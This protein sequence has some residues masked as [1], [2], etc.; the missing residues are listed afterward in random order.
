LDFDPTDA[1]PNEQRCVQDVAGANGQ[2]E[3]CGAEVQYDDQN[4]MDLEE[5]VEAL[6][7]ALRNVLTVHAPD[8]H[9]C[10]ACALARQ[11]VKIEIERLD[12]T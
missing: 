4:E 5:R 10:N 12:K 3:E 9:E 1:E 7:L 8:G 11:L 2:R 6:E